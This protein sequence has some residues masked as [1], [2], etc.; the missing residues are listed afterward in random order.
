LGS[1]VSLPHETSVSQL[2]PSTMC[3]NGRFFMD[4]SSTKPDDSGV[5]A[6]VMKVGATVWIRRLETGVN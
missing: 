6:R 2:R 4:S 1:V 5:M 3:S